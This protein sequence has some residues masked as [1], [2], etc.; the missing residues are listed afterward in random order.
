MIGVFA[1]GITQEAQPLPPAAPEPG[2]KNSWTQANP[3]VCCESIG[4]GYRR[5]QPGSSFLRT[6]YFISTGRL[7]T[8]AT[9]QQQT[10]VADTARR[11]GF[12]NVRQ[13]IHDGG[14]AVKLAHV[15]EALRWFRKG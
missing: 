3:S 6:P 7:D 11:A 12:T 9:V 14:H 2:V 5:F 15:Q 10:I 13:R 8:I 4:E 1:S